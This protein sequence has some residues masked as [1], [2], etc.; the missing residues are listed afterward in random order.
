[1]QYGASITP[2]SFLN[3]SPQFFT[4]QGFAH[5]LAQALQS[6]GMIPLSQLNTY[7]LASPANAERDPLTSENAAFFWDYP[8][9]D[10]YTVAGKQYRPLFGLHNCM[11]YGF[12]PYNVGISG[13]VF[14]YVVGH[15][16]GFMPFRRRADRILATD[17]IGIN[18]GPWHNNTAFYG[19]GT[20]GHPTS[21]F[22]PGFVG[23]LVGT[24]DWK[25]FSGW[26]DVS[27]QQLLFVNRVFVHLS[28]A[29]LVIQVG[30]H[31]SRRD[32]TANIY[33]IMAA[34]HGGRIPNRA[35]APV[36]DS[37]RDSFD[38][39]AWFDLGS[40]ENAWYSNSSRDEMFTALLGAARTLGGVYQSI[41]YPC[42]AYLRSIDYLDDAAVAN[43]PHD[44]YPRPSPT[45]RGGNGV[46]LLHR[47]CLVP[48][49]R[50]DGG[51][52]SGRIESDKQPTQ[53]PLTRWEDAFYLPGIALSDR[54]VPPGPRLD[55]ITGKTWYMIW[56]SLRQQAFGIDYTGVTTVSQ[57]IPG[58]GDPTL[59]NTIPLNLT[60]LPQTNLAFTRNV[61]RNNELAAIGAPRTLIG[62]FGG[63]SVYAYIIE[64]SNVDSL[65]VNRWNKPAA[66]NGFQVLQYGWQG[67][68][69]GTKY[70][71]LSLE[72]EGLSTDPR[73]FYS[74]EVDVRA[75]SPSEAYGNP[76]PY[77]NRFENINMGSG[78]LTDAVNQAVLAQ[79][80]D[81][82]IGTPAYQ[83]AYY[84]YLTYGTFGT[85]LP[86]SA[87]RRTNN[88][89]AV[90]PSAAGHATWSLNA[91]HNYGDP[92][93]AYSM[94][95][96]AQNF[97]LKQYRRG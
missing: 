19:F 91:V 9:N 33:N 73:D 75:R 94:D 53:Q 90:T 20:A 38:P 37:L 67:G 71:N 64:L 85:P 48:D 10:T 84:N 97:V 82:S 54:V 95:V 22:W 16:V 40:A 79:L 66:Y 47:A 15:T 45:V 24:N 56:A 7:D 72:F 18:N 81:L 58:A 25:L 55:P 23:G 17:F 80:A 34:F 61:V 49:Q 32:E 78:R 86:P 50:T 96:E 14:S 76:L 57:P 70:M 63:I 27:M 60:A 36:N 83:N 77:Y 68:Y 6:V 35:M 3:T 74:I 11:Y 89:L 41:D 52:F 29:G 69:D 31:P 12:Y 46:H 51:V 30:T 2:K 21:S 26:G 13:K 88:I 39:V 87:P 42:Y 1:M 59:L 62:V 8:T 43:T 65:L 4:K 93:P 92:N 44:N 28:P 5:Y